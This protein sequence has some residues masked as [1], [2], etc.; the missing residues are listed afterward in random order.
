MTVLTDLLRS[1]LEK[2]FDLEQLKRLSSELLGLDPD[3]VGGGDGKGAFARALVERS[4]REDAL[5]ALTDAL[6]VSAKGVDDRVRKI[7]D[8]VGGPELSVGTVVAGFRIV[9]KLG[10]GGL[11]IVYL[12]ERKE[13]EVVE[14]AALKVIRTE[15][16]RDRAAVQ[17]FLT[18]SRVLRTVKAPTLAPVLA[19][20][21]LDDG[22]P[23]VAS[24]YVEG[25]VLAARLSRVGPMHFNEARGVVRDV[26]DALETLH[27]RGLVH[28]DV[29]TENV[30]VVRMTSAD[31]RTG[32]GGVLVDGG[33]DRLLARPGAPVDRTGVLPVFG[34]AKAIAP[35][36]AR[37]ARLDAR[38]DVYAFGALLFEVLTGKP[39]FSGPSV[40][41][42]VTRHLRDEPEAPS[43]VAP[44][45]WVSRELDEIVLRALAKTP[46]ARFPSATAVREALD[47]LARQSIRPPAEKVSFDARQFEA[48]R[49]ALLGKPEDEELA[50]AV[51]RIAGPAAEWGKAVEAFAA[52]AEAAESVDAKKSLLFRIARIEEHERKDHEAAEAA[53][54]KILALDPR[55]EIAQVAIEE[56]RRQSGNHEGLVEVLLEK[57]E[58]TE[59]AA[60][61]ARIL[62]EIAGI[63]EEQ[64]SQPDA[65]FVA[66]VQAL[67]E[68]PDDARAVAEIERLAG[69]S[70]DRWNEALSTLSEAVRADIDP[71]VKVRLYVL[72]GGWYADKLQRPDFALPCFAQALAIDPA[73]EPALE[74]TIALY[75]KAQAWPDLVAILLRRADAATQ[76]AR[77]RD[78]RVEAAEVLANKLNDA[79]RARELLEQVLADDP[80]HE[81][82]SALLEE[83]L[84]RTQEW[85]G[86]VALVERKAKNLRGAA[87]VEALCY[88]AEIY[89][90]RLSDLGKAR[91]RF[92]EALSV[93]PHDLTA[94][95]GLERIYAREGNAQELLANL[96]TQVE[97]AATPR[98]KIGLLERIGGILEEEFVDR[99]RAAATFEQI[100]AI[101]PGHDAAN[102]ALARLYRH[103]HRFDALA[104]TLDRHAKGVDDERRKVELLLAAARVLMV[105]VGAPERALATAQRVLSIDPENAQALELVARLQAQTGDAAAALSATERLAEGERDPAKKAELWI[106]AGKILEERGD[107]DRAI[108]KY[109]LA[110]DADPRSAAAFA[111][112]RVIYSERGDAHGA[113][114]LL[115]REI[116][117]TDGPVAKSKLYAELGTLRRERLGDAAGARDAF[118]RALE[119]DATNTPAARGLGELAFA[120][121][122]WAEA[123]KYLEPLLSRTSELATDVARGV[124]V[125]A[126]DAFRKLGVF[127]KAQRAYLNAKALAPDDRDVLERV[128]ELTFEGGEADEAAEL[129]RDIL[130]RFDTRLVGADRG[131]I[132]L[133]IGQAWRKAGDLDEAAKA[134]GEAADLLPGDPA[135]LEE[136]AA[137]FDAK[138]RWDDLIGTLRRR[139]EHAA[140]DERFALLVRIGDV[141]LEKKQEKA[142]A[143]KAYVQALELRADDRNL[144]TKLMA[145]YSEVKDWSRLVEVVLRIAELVTDKKQLAKYYA[146]AAAISHLELK[147]YEEAADYYEQALENDPTAARA[148]E[149][150]IECITQAEDW[151]R[152][153][154]AYRKQ[155]QRIEGT[156]TPQER[157]AIWDALAELLRHKLGRVAQAVEALEK[158]QELDPD[159]RRRAENLALIYQSDPRRFFQKAV[160]QQQLLLAQSPYRIESYQ[161]LR[162]LYTELKKADE[163]WCV[164]QALHC[165][166]QAEPDETAFFKKHRTRQPAVAK[167]RF[168]EEVWA[169]HVVHPDQDPLL[170]GIFAILSGAAIAT[171]S[172]PLSA[173][174]VDPSRKRDAVNDPAVMAQMLHYASGVTDIPLPDIYYRE[175]DPGGLSL[176]FSQPPAIG[177]G[178]GALAGGPAQ[179]LAFVAGRQLSFLRPGHYMRHLVPTGGGLRAWL[180]AA[181]K[182]SNPQFP[183]PPD[184]AGSVTEHLAAIKQHVSPPQQEQLKSAVQKL[185][186][187]APELNLKRWVAAVD[188][189]A[190]RVGF[191]LANDLELSLAVVQASPEESAAVGHK[192]RIKELTLYSVSEA[193]MALRYKLGIA[194]GAE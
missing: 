165:L 62:H 40:V 28:G 123:A 191:V 132:L 182:L 167:E 128:A 57:V 19:V 74:G 103:L 9:K 193:Y 31:G 166:K 35:E 24:G 72:M 162:K 177:L 192:D 91:L 139:L 134:L 106:R 133:R 188:L 169:R 68:S 180:L 183:V 71:Q 73:C 36:Q 52:A 99:E 29:K 181:I 109:K 82:A 37:G 152:L 125:A 161:A 89:E 63:Y 151:N 27:D 30:F 168:T 141:Y 97:L 178:K 145:L 46:E 4:I 17:R 131:R 146:T 120:D 78:A 148:Y 156:A 164:C 159:N 187:A 83:L 113:A 112:L 79:A 102:T 119:L 14:R 163:S 135:P 67:T 137:V 96:R 160:A 7:F 76:A 147:R 65:A 86:L 32:L 184:L 18:I 61:R 108:E 34:T 15:Y 55:E 10:E 142:G 95:K 173:F 158:A 129:Y 90:D 94:I 154:E 144:L 111:C 190:D 8:G 157:A 189:T 66:W 80:I 22:R 16:A 110:L 171:R 185:L 122:N 5:E 138:G 85:A 38:T 176:L 105:D 124:A 153:E 33:T 92:E 12:A 149:G 194:I 126:G 75:R 174:G 25:Q 58:R 39:V 70:A 59:D 44:R 43:K 77:G 23:W 51:E 100:V 170:T 117:A 84:A 41:D 150:L 121:G 49:E 42:V 136:L 127:D 21:V 88:A 107:K 60:E 87:K 179:A 26:L 101:E 98:Q 6:L 53:Y 172:Q 56:L 186:A 47:A 54:R 48:A 93:D 114:E 45:G 64:L 116:A 11:G 155:L 130:R 115:I 104:E 143:Q 13:G 50:V 2:H 69:T 3:D 1:E 20:G 140:D 175:S 118:L 81:R